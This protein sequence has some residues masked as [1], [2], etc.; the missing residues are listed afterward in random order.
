[1]VI[2]VKLMSW[3]LAGSSPAVRIFFL[4]ENGPSQVYLLVPLPTPPHTSIVL[5]YIDLHA[6]FQQIFIT[7]TGKVGEWLIRSPTKRLP[8]GS[9]VRTSFLSFCEHLF[10]FYMK[11]VNLTLF[12]QK[13]KCIVCPKPSSWIQGVTTRT[14]WKV[15][16]CQVSILGT[17]G[18][19]P[20]EIPLL[21]NDDDDWS[22]CWNLKICMWYIYT[23]N[24]TPREGGE[25][26]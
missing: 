23:K 24:C 19:E 17:F 5:I 8:K 11:P 12:H 6:D 25:E 14:K 15:Y 22:I 26:A 7:A 4:H 10:F 21:H 20:N 18:Y 9:W 1:M 3:S 13:K 2:P 16:R